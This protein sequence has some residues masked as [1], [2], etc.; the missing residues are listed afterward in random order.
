MRRA[1]LALLTVPLVALALTGCIGPF[2]M[3]DG[4]VVHNYDYDT[5]GVVSLNRYTPAKRDM[6]VTF[7]FYGPWVSFDMVGSIL[8]KAGG[9]IEGHRVYMPIKDGRTW[10]QDSSKGIKDEGQRECL[11]FTPIP[12]FRH[13]YLH[14]RFYGNPTQKY[15]YN[16]HFGRYVVGTSHLDHREGCSGAWSGHADAAEDQWVAGL[17]CVGGLKITRHAI[18]MDNAE[19]A[20]KDA[21]HPIYSDGWATK[22]YVP[23]GLNPRWVC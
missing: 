14:M 12:T 16:S 1:R 9:D 13:S 15:S 22:V 6:P 20:G 4:D 2:G 8:R 3:G 5:G 17:R 23:A 10:Q 21:P 11:V 18:F 7:V 19:R